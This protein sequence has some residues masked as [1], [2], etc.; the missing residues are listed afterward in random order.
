M[1][2]STRRSG[3]PPTYA[4][5][6]L[7]GTAPFPV[8]RVSQSRSAEDM[9][10]A[11]GSPSAARHARNP[12][13]CGSGCARGGC[14]CSGWNLRTAADLP[15]RG[16]RAAAV[17]HWLRPVHRQVRVAGSVKPVSEEE[18]NEYW[19]TRP[20]ATRRNAAA[21]ASAELRRGGRAQP[22]SE[23]GSRP[24]GRSRHAGCRCIGEVPLA[25]VLASRP[26]SA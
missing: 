7:H 23:A 13:R 4:A 20:A 14:W 19:R 8:T 26:V 5:R 2:S 9:S 18:A 1:R 3:A 21:S 16:D 11:R 17:L 6:A 22:V 10:G 15:F 25:D 24:S 12:A